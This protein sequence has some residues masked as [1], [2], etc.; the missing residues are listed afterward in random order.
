MVDADES[1]PEFMLRVTTSRIT[2]TI[3][4]SPSIAN[5]SRYVQNFGGRFVRKRFPQ[6]REE[7][8]PFSRLPILRVAS[9][10]ATRYHQNITDRNVLS[11]DPM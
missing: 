11:N 6:S 4:N 1:T 7:F 5:Q 2:D 10:E 8:L 3:D 9:D